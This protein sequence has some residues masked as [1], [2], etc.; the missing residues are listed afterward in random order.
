MHLGF[1]LATAPGGR[2]TIPGQRGVATVA[3]GASHVGDQRDAERDLRPLRGHVEPILETLTP[4]TYLALQKMSDEEMAWGKR[5]YM[6]G[7]FLDEL[8]DADFHFSIDNKLMGQVNLVRYGLGSVVDGGS[9]TITSGILAQQ[10]S[11]G[12]AAI[13]LVNAGLEGF[14]RAAALEAP[15]GIRI[16]VVSPPW[17]TETLQALGMP[18]QGGLPAATVAQAYVACV[19]GTATGQVISP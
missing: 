1:G 17:V 2:G 5:F 7:A 9:I 19:E 18:L 10:P 3:V 6:K 4:T 11:R 16:N 8:S 12:S 15:R 13:S 14:A